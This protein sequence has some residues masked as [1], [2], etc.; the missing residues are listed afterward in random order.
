[1]SVIVT[2][3]V[4]G[5]TAAVGITV[6]LANYKR[7]TSGVDGTAYTAVVFPDEPRVPT[8]TIVFD[9]PSEKYMP[10]E[11]KKAA[12]ARAPRKRKAA[13]QTTETKSVKGASVDD[14]LILS[15]VSNMIL[16]DS[17]S[18][19]VSS[20]E[21]E[22]SGGG[23]SSGGAGATASWEPSTSY[24]SSYDSSSSSSSYDSSSSS[25]DSSSSSGS[26]D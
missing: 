4:L 9:D 6:I 18:A 13:V 24:S 26:S 20:S 1:M 2:V 15:A 17:A 10:T 16:A 23:G 8:E 5:V 7:R 3:S 14:T 25:S 11:V 21:T 19:V 12:P 22:F